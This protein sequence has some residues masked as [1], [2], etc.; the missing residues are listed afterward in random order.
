MYVWEVAESSDLDIS[1][2]AGRVTTDKMRLMDQKVNLGPLFR[3]V[4]FSFGLAMCVR[5]SILVG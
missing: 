3:M 4:Y 5:E 2:R 1:K